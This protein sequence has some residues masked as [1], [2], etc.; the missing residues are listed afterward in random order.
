VKLSRLNTYLLVGIIVVN[1]ITIGLPFVPAILFRVQSH[2]TK[3]QQLMHEV[4]SV[5]V[6]PQASN[7]LIMP[8]AL[9]DEPVFDG[10][11]ARTLRQGVWHRPASSTPDKGG[12]TVFAGHRFTYTDPQGSFYHLDKVNIGDRIGVIWNKLI[13]RY[14]VT[15]VRVVGPNE[16]SIEAP[17]TDARL[18]VYTC[19]P[20]TLPKDRLVVIAKPELIHER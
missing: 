7:S 16:T 17:T 1:G 15:E 5:D 13:Y 3:R 19:T 4:M 11:D 9:F 14:T 6:A 20:L 2:G 12:N 10:P 18:T 8:T